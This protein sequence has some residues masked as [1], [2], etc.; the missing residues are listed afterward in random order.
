MTD[1]SNLVFKNNAFATNKTTKKT[2]RVRLYEDI[3]NE[4]YVGIDIDGN[5]LSSDAYT[6]S[7]ELTD[8]GIVNAPKITFWEL[9]KKQIIIV[10][11]IVVLATAFGFLKYK[12]VI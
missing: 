9:Y 4:K 6:F 10:G 12:K 7:N 3:K 5:K 11:S 8:D 2:V 1:L